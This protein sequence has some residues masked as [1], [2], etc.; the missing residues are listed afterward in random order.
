VY[1]AVILMYFISAAVILLAS[2]ALMFQFSLPY[3]K[4]GRAGSECSKRLST[5]A[6]VAY[7]KVLPVE[8]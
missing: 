1:P 5:N 7:R 3:N 4:A 8:T 2:L 6:N